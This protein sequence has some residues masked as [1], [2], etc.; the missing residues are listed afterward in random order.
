MTEIFEI[1]QG[2]PGDP[3]YKKKPIIIQGITGTFG[4]VHAK[5]M[6]A[7]GVN[8]AAGVTPGKG[9]KKFEG[10][11]IYNTVKEAVDATGPN[12]C[13]AFFCCKFYY[14]HRISNWDVFWNCN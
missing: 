10:V 9:G 13:C 12:D 2:N 6:I 1:L 5:N 8:V 11:P 4:S 3:D 7:Y 14:L